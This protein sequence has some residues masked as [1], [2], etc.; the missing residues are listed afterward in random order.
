MSWDSGWR[1]TG[2]EDGRGMKAGGFCCVS[3]RLNLLFSHRFA[4]VR[5]HLFFKVISPH[6]FFLLLRCRN[7]N[8]YCLQA[9]AA[10]RQTH[11]EA[12][13]MLMLWIHTKPSLSNR[14]IN[15]LEKDPHTWWMQINTH[16]QIPTTQFQHITL[17]ILLE[18]IFLQVST[19][20]CDV[21]YGSISFYKFPLLIGATTQ[22]VNFSLPKSLKKN[23]CSYEQIGF[24]F[25]ISHLIDRELRSNNGMTPC[26]T[27]SQLCAY[28]SYE[29][30]FLPWSIERKSNLITLTSSTSSITLVS[31]VFPC[32]RQL[33]LD[34]P[35]S[36][37]AS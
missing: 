6:F 2:K 1:R 34:S 7:K 19:V 17:E 9:S 10:L 26:Y 13:I 18:E 5:S 22:Y 24:P 27:I 29:M 28:K 20:V 25:F 11:V 37:I 32:Y 3:P 21:C 23:H 14:S 36:H 15:K 4:H 35:L 8:N 12:C 33:I 16:S 30:K 31:F